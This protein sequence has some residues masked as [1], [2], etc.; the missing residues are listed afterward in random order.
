MANMIP[1]E[2]DTAVNTWY[3]APLLFQR[4]VTSRRPFN[5][6]PTH[7]Y[8]PYIPYHTI[9]YGGGCA[10][11]G[12]EILKFWYRRLVCCT[13]QDTT[14]PGWVL[15]AHTIPVYCTTAVVLAPPITTKTAVPDTPHA[16]KRTSTTPK[17]G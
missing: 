10:R 6:K 2:R 9:S 15:K 4:T 12:K 1:T 16:P 7:Y 8:E 13:T 11:K 3:H 17:R 14:P 5:S